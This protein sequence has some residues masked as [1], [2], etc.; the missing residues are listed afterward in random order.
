MA[1]KKTD[2]RIVIHLACPTCKERTY[3]TQKNRKNDT[4]RLEINKYCPR[5]K[6]HTLHK[7]VK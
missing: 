5:C 7:E 6:T 2:T 4:Q 3:T 1:S